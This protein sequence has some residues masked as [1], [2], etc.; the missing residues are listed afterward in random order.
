[1]AGSSYMESTRD[2]I[3]FLPISAG[4]VIKIYLEA[5]KFQITVMAVERSSVSYTVIATLSDA[6]QTKSP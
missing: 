6:Q 5:I 3:S 1:M 2:H 4:F